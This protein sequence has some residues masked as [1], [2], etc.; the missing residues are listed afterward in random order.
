MEMVPTPSINFKGYYGN[1]CPMAYCYLLE[2][3]FRFFLY[4]KKKTEMASRP[5]SVSF[6]D[7]LFL[8]N[9]GILFEGSPCALSGCALCIT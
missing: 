8:L 9:L 3:T 2:V 6:S 4:I 1:T 7:D 5:P